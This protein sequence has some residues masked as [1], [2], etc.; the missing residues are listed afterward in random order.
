MFDA[1]GGWRPLM[2]RPRNCGHDETGKTHDVEV[3]EE[4]EITEVE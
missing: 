3:T 2:R 4:C 1:D